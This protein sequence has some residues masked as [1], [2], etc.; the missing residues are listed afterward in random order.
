[1]RSMH[2]LVCSPSFPTSKTIDFVFVEQLCRAFA[3]LGHQVSV[4]AP[5]SLTKCLMR[6]IPVVPR[7]SYYYTSNG[8]KI[9]LYRPYFITLGNKGQKLIGNAFQKAVLRAFNGLKS[10]P[11]VCYGHF[12]QSIFA[13]YP[14]AKKKGIPLFGASG[15]EFVPKYVNQ[16]ASF[17]KTISNYISGIVSVSTKNQTECLEMGLVDKS[18]SIVIPNA[19]DQ[20]LFHQLD[21]KDCRKELG[22]EHNVF[23]VAFVGQFVPRK[24]TM[25]LNAALEKIGDPEIK[26]VFIGTGSDDPDYE[27]IIHKGRLAHDEIPKWLNAADVFVL[28]TENEGCCNAII[29]AMA[30]GLPVISTDAPFNYDI[31]NEENSIM[32]DCHDIDRIADSIVMLKENIEKHDRLSK[33]ALATV[34]GLSIEK[35]AERIVNYMVKQVSNDN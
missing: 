17:I 19:I 3:D 14:G 28:P 32:V 6:H 7:H 12:W 35:R 24:G 11:D 15:E 9:E 18:K 26:A 30:C 13:L 25:R 20:M 1:M 33:G 4:I 5:Q 34:A 16:P 27:G 8:G 31:L 22:I 29:E 21:K 10:K 23:V 2:I